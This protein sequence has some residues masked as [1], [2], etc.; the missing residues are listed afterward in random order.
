MKTM[1]FAIGAMMSLSGF[2]V[3][4]AGEGG[5]VGPVGQF[6]QV[7]GVVAGASEQT[8]RPLAMAGTAASPQY[9][10]S[11][12]HRGTWLFPANETGGGN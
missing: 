6:A 4:Y 2:G 12:A 8:V 7:A 9:F 5:G 10:F 3:A 11:R 1:L